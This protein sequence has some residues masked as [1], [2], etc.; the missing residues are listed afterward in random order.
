VPIPGI[1]LVFFVNWSKF[2]FIYFYHFYHLHTVVLHTL[3]NGFHPV[4][5][6]TC[7]VLYFLKIEPCYNDIGLCVTSSIASHFVWYQLIIYCWL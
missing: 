4:D 5:T 3:H 6:T 7:T 2:I 1:S